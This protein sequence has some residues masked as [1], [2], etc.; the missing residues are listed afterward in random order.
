[1]TLSI[2]PALAAGEAERLLKK[3]QRGLFKRKPVRTLME[4]VHLPARIVYAGHSTNGNPIE[5]LVNGFAESADLLLRETLEFAEDESITGYAYP[6]TNE[7][8]VEIA[9]R[10]FLQWKLN[11]LVSG[12]AGSDELSVGEILHYPYW[13]RYRE[14]RSGIVVF[15]AVDGITARLAGPVLKQAILDGLRS[16]TAD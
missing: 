7:R 2:V 6:L 13:L 12:N 16:G 11:R 8:T 9:H 5:I 14:K 15:D 3:K 10:T 4:L 1:M